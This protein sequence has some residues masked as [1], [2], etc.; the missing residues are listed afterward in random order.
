[1]G[2]SPHICNKKKMTVSV[3]EITFNNAGHE[4]ILSPVVLH[5]ENEIVLVDCGYPGFMPLIEDAMHQ[6]GLSLEHTTGIIITHDDIDHV[7]A[8]FEIKEKYP[9]IKVYSSVIAEKYISGKEKSP[10]LLQA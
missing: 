3:L 9:L 2:N 10:R 5:N 6:H 1:M 7:G 8:L 4:A